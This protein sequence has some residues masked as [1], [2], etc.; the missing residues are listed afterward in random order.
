MDF[1][2]IFLLFQFDFLGLR[3]KKSVIFED[4]TGLKHKYMISMAISFLR[5]EYWSI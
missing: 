5:F 3:A 4:A 1:K 2:T